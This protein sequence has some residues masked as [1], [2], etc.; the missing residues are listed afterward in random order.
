MVSGTQSAVTNVTE[1]AEN[2]T[3]GVATNATEGAE[4][5]TE[6]TGIR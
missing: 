6:G 2:A 5:A 4:N 3:E 1:G